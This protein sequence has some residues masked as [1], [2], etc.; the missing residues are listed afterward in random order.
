M[1]HETGQLVKSFECL[2]PYAVLEKRLFVVYFVK[3]ISYSNIFFVEINSS[4]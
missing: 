2:L 1:S 4:L 3:K